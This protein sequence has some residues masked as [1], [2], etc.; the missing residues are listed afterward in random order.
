MIEQTCGTTVERA[1]RPTRSSLLLW[2]GAALLFA[3]TVVSYLPAFG[4]GYIWDDDFYVTENPLLTAPDG[5][6]RIW[7]STDSPS[8]YFPLVYTTF[9]IE[10]SIWGLDPAGYHITNIVV[11]AL[12]ALLLWWLLARLGIGPAWLAA[13]L[14]ALHPVHAESVA[15]ITERKNVLMAFFFFLSLLAWTEFAERS[16]ES[17]RAIPFYILS[18][19]FFVLSLFSKTTACTIPAALVLILWMKGF[20][21]DLRRWMQIVPFVLLGAAMGFLSIWWEQNVHNVKMTGLAL[22][23]V[24]RILVASR[25]IWFYLYK[26]VW[27]TDL[28]FSYTK[29]EIDPADPLQ[30]GWL[31]ALGLVL[32]AGWRWRGAL[33]RGIISGFVFFVATL[34][35]MLGFFILWTFTY[36]YVADHYQYVAAVGITTIIAALGHDLARRAGPGMNRVALGAAA[37]ILIALG[38]MTWNRCHAYENSETLWYDTISKSSNSWMGHLNLGNIHHARDELDEASDHFR[39]AL[40]I[41]PKCIS[42]RNNLANI[43][44]SR[45]RVDEAIAEYR[46]ALRTM[47]FEPALNHNLAQALK[48]QGKTDE[49]IEHYRRVLKANPSHAQAHQD[50][51]AAYQSQGRLRLAAA[52]FRAALAADPKAT[53]ALFQLAWILATSDDESIRNPAEAISL[54]ERI[55]R[56]TSFQNARALDTLAVAYASAGRFAEAVS[57][58]QKAID[59]ARSEGQANVAARIEKH[60]RLFRAGMPL[61][62]R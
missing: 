7:F 26:L 57:T 40:E 21:L 2:C 19:L 4:A 23:P 55:C 59:F 3:M 44:I 48:M 52:H 37:A 8:Q 61:R 51:A 30:Y 1:A 54:A 45:D 6:S 58:A 25:A 16:S 22:G 35:P 33:G 49:A 39:A 20:R 29:W 62:T 11:H 32:L 50:L 34:V 56:L 18:I 60:L 41:N 5:L 28:S 31:A 36:T 14:F 24:E 13:A 12:N 38:A 27:P 43:L 46:L 53:K 17:R 9:R 42:A 10:H 15:W 47:P